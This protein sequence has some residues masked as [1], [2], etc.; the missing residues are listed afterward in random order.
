MNEQLTGISLHEEGIPTENLIQ[1][2]RYLNEPERGMHSFMLLRHGKVVTKAWWAPYAP[3]KPHSLF[4][5]SKT[6]TGLAAGFAIQE[7]KLRLDDK[8]V[9][10]FPDYLPSKTCENMEKMKVSNLLTMTSGFGKDPHD[11]TF[12]RPDDVIGTGPHCCHQGIEPK[13][14]DWIRNFFDHYVPYEPGHDFVYCTHGTYILSAI[15]QRAVGCTVSEYLNRKLFRPLGIDDPF[16]E[17]SPDGTSVGG[18]GL[19]LTTEQFARVGQF[20]LSRGRWDG[21]QILNE[22]WIADATSVHIGMDH[23]DEPNMAGYGYQLWIGKEEGAYYFRGAFGQICAVIP[24][25]DMVIIMTGASDN[26]TRRD[27]WNKI[28]N[29]LVTPADDAESAPEDS[30]A[31]GESELN[32]MTKSFCIKPAEGAASWETGVSARYSGKHYIFGDNRLN[33]TDFMMT[34]ASAPDQHDSLTLGLSGKTF[35][36]PVGYK[37]WLHGTTCVSDEETDT[38]TSIIFHSVSCTGAWKDDTYILKMC[39]D[40]TSYINTLEIHFRGEGALI[41]HRRNCSFFSAVNSDL[42]GVSI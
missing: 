26:V 36:V 3:E 11:F 20:M 8:V 39:F 34:F 22:D 27:T 24:G 18:W 14:I 1:V 35:T 16:W 38:D 4:S 41:K 29:L 23:L 30:D 10:W 13:P 19:N 7:G 31:G 2:Y 5:A 28:W 17:M 25:K 12:S 37:T 40:E 15:V 32:E 9:S 42:T 33:F 6:F 21:K